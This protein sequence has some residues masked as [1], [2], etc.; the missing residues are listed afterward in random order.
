VQQ[1][2]QQ[3]IG[4]KPVNLGNIGNLNSYIPGIR[5]RAPLPVEQSYN[6]PIKKV[7]TEVDSL[8]DG[9]KFDLSQKA[10]AQPPAPKVAPKKKP[11]PAPR[12]ANKQQPKVQGK[13]FTGRTCSGNLHGP[14]LMEDPLLSN[15]TQ[16]GFQMSQFNFTSPQDLGDFRTSG[17]LLGSLDAGVLNSPAS[18]TPLAQ[19]QTGDTTFS[20][21]GIDNGNAK[22]VGTSSKGGAEAKQAAPSQSTV[23]LPDGQ[24]VEIIRN[25]TVG[26]LL[27]IRLPEASLGELAEWGKGLLAVA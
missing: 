27:S 4:A 15:H 22:I 1:W 19:V 20:Y 17:L 2:N 25:A 8:S 7:A 5:T 24:T 14:L 6:P 21:Y 3:R 9:M 23:T 12:Q 13:D 26:E 11:A 16:S 10:Q 18:E